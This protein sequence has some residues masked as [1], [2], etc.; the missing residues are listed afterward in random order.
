LLTIAFAP[1]QALVF[2]SN[3]K[4]FR[5]GEKGAA[6]VLAFAVRAFPA[7]FL[8]GAAAGIALYAASPLIPVLL[9]TSFGPS[10]QALRWLSL[11][12]LIQGTHYL[13]GDALMGAGKQAIRSGFQLGTAGVNIILNLA[14]I[15]MWSWRGAAIASLISEFLLAVAL[16][17]TLYVTARYGTSS[18]STIEP[19]ADKGPPA[20]VEASSK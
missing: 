1:I 4:L 13:F 18:R 5:D 3:T 14:L 15:P 2:S 9:G 12:P 8:Y 17:G 16:V 10:V 7:V 19:E 11:M 6:H 20:I